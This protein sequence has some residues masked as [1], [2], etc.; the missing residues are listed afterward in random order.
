LP[1]ILARYETATPTSVRD[2]DEVNTPSLAK[3]RAS[4]PD[5]TKEFVVSILL[6]LVDF[7][8]VGKSM[9]VVQI[10]QTADLILQE[11]FHLKP[12]D[13]KLVFNRAKAG[14][15]GTLFDRID[16][17]VIL[18]WLREYDLK[19]RTIYFSEKS[20]RLHDE[21]K[22]NPTPPHPEARRLFAEIRKELE[23]DPQVKKELEEKAKD[24]KFKQYKK[25]YNESRHEN[26]D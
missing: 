2:I 14:F 16:G 19:E 25:Q 4:N 15:Y 24:N 23:T 12:E 5:I 3:M 20:I 8:S 7:F 9:G 1:K 21:Q 22:K 10:Q 17:Q 6:D 11:F 13:L 18:S 26:A